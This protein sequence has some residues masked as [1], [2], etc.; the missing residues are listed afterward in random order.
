MRTLGTF[1]RSGLRQVTDFVLEVFV[2][3]ME[4]H[5]LLADLLLTHQAALHGGGRLPAGATLSCSAAVSSRRP[6]ARHVLHVV[7]LGARPHH[8]VV[9]LQDLPVSDSVVDGEIVTDF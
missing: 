2:S 9:V 5:R 7:R 1:E 6:T 3:Q 4:D 8:S